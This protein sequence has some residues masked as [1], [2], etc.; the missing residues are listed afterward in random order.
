MMR[1][2]FAVELDPS[3]A[4]GLHHAIEPLRVLE[5]GLAWVPPAKLH[6]TMKFVGDA[7]E[8]GAT[9]LKAAAD[10]TA[11]QHRKMDMTLGGVGAFPNFRRARVV[12]MGVE[13]EPRLEWLHHD[14]EV[15][16]AAAGYEV[17]GRAFRPHITFA[18][19]RTPLPIERVRLL[20]RAARRVA[21]AEVSEVTHLTLFESSPGA[22][23]HYRRVHAAPL[24]GR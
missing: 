8:A 16:C 5:P 20:A 17:E 10:A 22:G 1:L 4:E 18:R 23:A 21:F 13:N 6:L 2:F 14:L 9:A 7:D 12:W 3:I 24:G 11:A 19:V 15:A